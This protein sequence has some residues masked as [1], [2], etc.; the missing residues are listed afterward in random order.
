MIN[1]Y[2]N[3]EQKRSGRIKCYE[4]GSLLNLSEL[5]YSQSAHRF[6][7]KIQRLTGRI[8]ETFLTSEL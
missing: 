7:L 4:A 3:K 8:H 2:E 1:Y 5:A 6:K